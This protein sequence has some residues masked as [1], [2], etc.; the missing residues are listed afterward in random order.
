MFSSAT[1]KGKVGRKTTVMPA[2][3]DD[4]DEAMATLR[5][6]ADEKI[7]LDTEKLDS[8]IKEQWIER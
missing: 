6:V 1:C 2:K 4:Y 7:F 3:P 8:Y 5:G